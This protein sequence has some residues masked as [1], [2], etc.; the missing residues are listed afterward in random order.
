MSYNYTQSKVKQL[1]T[2]KKAYI[3]DTG[4]ANSL[5]KQERIDSPEYLGQLAETQVYNEISR[6]HQALFWRDKMQHEV[7]IIAKNKR[8]IPVEV[9]YRATISTGDIKNMEFFMKK[10][11]TARGIIVTKDLFREEKRLL[12]I[13]AWLF[14][15][16]YE[17]LL[18]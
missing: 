3:N 14:L 18:E 1:R 17:T 5:L 8:I 6:R 15:L 2:S 10:N 11:N 7:D 16:S 9:K 4:I 13:P 12:Y